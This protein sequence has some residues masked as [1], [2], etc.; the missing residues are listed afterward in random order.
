[1]AIRHKRKNTSAYTWQTGD[2]VEGQIGLNI[3]DGTLHFDKSDGTT[4][5]LSNSTNNTTLLAY[6]HNSQ[7]STITKGQPVYLYQATGDKPSVKLAYNTSDTTSAKTLGL[8]AETMTT[9]ADGYVMVQG[10]ITG[11]NTAAYSEGDTLYLGATAGTLTATKPYAPNH[12][13]YIGVVA[14][15]NAGAGEI[16]VRPQNG[17]E[18][19]EIHDVNINHNV[20][21]ADKDYLVYNSSN[22]L[23]E[24]R[25]LDI[26]NDTTP[27]L[28][29]NL[30][31]NG[32]T[33]TS[34]SNA[35]VIVAPNGTGMIQLKS[36]VGT[37]FG[38]ST[39]TAYAGS[40]GT[41]DLIFKAN[42]A[43][44]SG[45]AITLKT[46]ANG[47]V[48]LYPQGSGIVIASASTT[49]LGTGAAAATLT[50]SGA[51]NLTVNTN[52]GT[53]SG[54]M[55]IA[56]GAN[57]N[58]VFSP[59]GTGYIKCTANTIQLGKNNT[60]T[61][62]TTQG[63]GTLTI[64]TNVG[65]NSGSI[66]I[67]NGA[68]GNIVLTP[69]GTG[70][71]QAINLN[72]TEVVYTSG[73]TTGTITPDVANGTIQSI[74]LTGSITFNAFSNPVSGQ[75]LTLI[76]KQSAAGGLTL[77]SS[78]LFAGASKTLSTAANAVD[79]LT[80]SYIGTTYYASLAKGFA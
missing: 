42:I 51:Y 25:Q 27:Q 63:T 43:N 10:K 3:A 41:Y 22:T 9:G 55:L 67:N 31:V 52:N 18:L 58:I 56:Q 35:D 34:A 75:T 49:Q 13:V 77:T 76:I 37:V 44:D 12:L 8:A 72:Y 47:N 6:V 39:A 30:D 11:I 60:A 68:N 66:V 79:I 54:S 59:N 74:T 15:A 40:N 19:D 32:K 17:Y 29:G 71:T 50:S 33:I 45:G 4:V 64:N 26:V 61:N 5:T 80:V 69:N 53:N 20:S 16:Y 2:L 23:W 38:D 70:Q 21:L 48:E 65:T 62:L 24:N 7:G 73:S 36:S 14:K 46:G 1:M 28:G 57:G 78:M